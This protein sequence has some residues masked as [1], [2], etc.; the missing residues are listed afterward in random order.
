MHS[1]GFSWGSR[2][3]IPPEDKFFSFEKNVCFLQHAIVFSTKESCWSYLNVR[4]KFF[5]C[6][7]NQNLLCD[8]RR[9]K[10]T[11]RVWSCKK[12]TSEEGM[13]LNWRWF[14]LKIVYRKNM[15]LKKYP[16]QIFFSQIILTS[17]MFFLSFLCLSLK[18]MQFYWEKNSTQ[19]TMGLKLEKN[20]RELFRR[21]NSFLHCG[22]NDTFSHAAGRRIWNFEISPRFQRW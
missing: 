6:G 16:S 9:I 17:R 5:C 2:Y 3:S 4:N 1:K 13:G 12:L 18:Y 15:S 22:V 20:L 21:K 19:I 7:A 11:V 8:P 14:P 10:E